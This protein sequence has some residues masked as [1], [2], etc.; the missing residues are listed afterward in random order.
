[1]RPRA[2][3]RSR[4]AAAADEGEHEQRDAERGAQRAGQ[5]EAPARL[6]RRVG[7]DQREREQ[8]RDADQGDVD[9]ED[10]L[11]AERPREHA[12]EEDAEH[13]ARGAGAAPDGQR[14]VALAALGER[15]V[16]QRQGRGEH[17]RSPEPLQ[18]AAGE[19]DLGGG[20]EASRQR[21]RGVEPEAA[22]EDP[23]PPQQIGRP[24]AEQQEAGGRDRVRADHQLQ[25]LRRV[26]EIPPDLREGHHHDVLVEGDDQHREG[27]Q[28]QRR[29]GPRASGPGAGGRCV[30]ERHGG[31]PGAG[32]GIELRSESDYNLIRATMPRARA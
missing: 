26:A 14:P 4:L 30:D 17:E 5:V 22:H 11:P 23:A 8:D 25:R 9:E 24:A 16:D 32:G 7:G 1:M 6:A 21:A 18:A 2:A 15:R 20:R 19:Q 10:G 13:E 28:R 31:T 29:R 3:S 27:Q 12:P